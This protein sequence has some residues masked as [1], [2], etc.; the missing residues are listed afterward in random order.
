[1]TVAITVAIPARDGW[2][3]LVNTSQ[4]IATSRS[5][6]DPLEIV[7]VDDASESSI[8]AQ[9]LITLKSRLRA[10]RASIRIVRSP[11]RLGV[12]RARNQACFAASG[13]ILVITDAHVRF[14]EGWD[15]VIRDMIAPKTILAGAISDPDSRF[16]AFGCDLVVPFMGTHWR[17]RRPL[18]GTPV[19]IAASPATVVLRETFEQVGGF[20]SGMRVYGGA[21]PEFS[22]RAW[23][24]GARVVSCPDFVVSHRFKTKAERNALFATTRPHML[25]NCIRFG[26]LYLSDTES[27]RMLRYLCAKFAAAAGDALHAVMTSDV[28]ERKRYLAD[29]LEFDFDWFAE[30]FGLLD[31]AGLPL[32][33]CSCD[34]G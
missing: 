30:R 16:L 17:R 9:E 12:A 1:M 20:D 15:D 31:Q 3:E 4:S 34:R 11:R 14:S 28:W 33:A 24:S 13:E 5:R 10:Y 26:L 21:E 27:L 22:V 29:H 2:A 6:R 32:Y 25:H 7:V 18:P 19:Q 23:L 8:P